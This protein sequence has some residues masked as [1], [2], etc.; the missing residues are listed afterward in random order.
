VPIL[1]LPDGTREPLVEG[2]LPDLQW[3]RFERSV[4][5]ED[6]DKISYKDLLFLRARNG[7]AQIEGKRQFRIPNPP[8]PVDLLGNIRVLSNATGKSFWVA[9]NLLEGAETNWISFVFGGPHNAKSIREWV[10]ANLDCI[11]TNGVIV[12][13][14]AQPYTPLFTNLCAVVIDRNTVKILP[15]RYFMSRQPSSPSR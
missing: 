11:R 15:A 1:Y 3:V 8:R 5:P 2:Q 10:R 4:T 9:H 14:Q 13:S 7:I 6:K 12:S